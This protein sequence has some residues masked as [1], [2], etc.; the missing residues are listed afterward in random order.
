MSIHESLRSMLYETADTSDCDLPRLRPSMRGT[1]ARR[2][3]A[4]ETSPEFTFDPVVNGYR[5]CLG[6]SASDKVAMSV[7]RERGPIPGTPRARNQALRSAL[8]AEWPD[9][10]RHLRLRLERH[11]DPGVGR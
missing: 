2:S 9:V 4:Q 6:P 5:T 1:P 8:A 11:R 10:K 7:Y 3:Y